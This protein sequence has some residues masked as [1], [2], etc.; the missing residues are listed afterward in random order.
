MSVTDEGLERIVLTR[1]L[2][3]NA[4]VHGIVTALFA[5]L[6][7]FIATN[8]LVVKGGDVV[9][10]HLGLLAQYFIGY[11][12]TFVGSLIGFA[13]AFAVG[14][15]AGYGLATLYNWFADHLRSWPSRR[16]AAGE[17]AGRS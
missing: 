14:F 1:V 11:D 2:R 3:L 12:V 15:V 8:W 13:Y 5:G 6:S 16:G 9:G 10:P 7:L 17:R 4:T